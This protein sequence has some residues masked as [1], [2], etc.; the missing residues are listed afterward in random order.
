MLVDCK[1]IETFRK[2]LENKEILIQCVY[3]Y[4]KYIY[5]W[6]GCFCF[7]NTF[8][9]LDIYYELTE[10]IVLYVGMKMVF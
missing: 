6:F 7:K 3:Y 10:N 8:G 9:V 4:G 5:D 1:A 2:M